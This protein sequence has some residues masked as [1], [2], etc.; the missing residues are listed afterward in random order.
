MIIDTHVHVVA[1][2]R[3]KY[4]VLPDA[5][6]WP[7]TEIEALVRDMDTVGVAK[8][9][10]VQTMFTYGFDNR[11][12]IDCAAKY[13]ARFETV[14]VIDPMAADSPAVLT[15]LVE[16]HRVKGVRLMPRGQKEGMLWDPQVFPLWRRA[17]ELG[18]PVTVAA[19]LPQ[20]PYMP[21]VVSRFPEMK[22]AFE[23]MWGIELGPPPFE[24]IAPI[25]ALA[26]F[27]NV[28][29]K[30]CPN[31]SHALRDAKGTPQQFFGA[32]IDR[33]GIRRM[34]WGSNYPAHAHRYGGLAARLQIMQED[35]AYLSAEERSWFF[36]ETALSLWPGLR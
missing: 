36:A 14:A 17:A 3:N 15:E 9:V 2:D 13:P 33:F 16:K 26:Q 10:L 5:P 23:H 11:Y 18:I 31:N 8:A 34:M 12:M 7:I 32:L 29:L 1:G 21:T 24:K 25:F 27:P 35:F 20:L 4:P 19:E 28:Y 22:I 30:L 6:D